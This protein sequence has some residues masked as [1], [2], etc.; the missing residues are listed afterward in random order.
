MLWYFISGFFCLSALSLLY[1][2]RKSKRQ[3]DEKNKLLAAFKGEHERLSIISNGT[4]NIIIIMDENGEIEW[5]NKVFT[6][7]TEYSLE[8]YKKKCGRTIYEVTSSP[9]L[10][11]IVNEAVKENKTM[12][13]ETFQI[14]S[15]GKKVWRASSISPIFDE[16]GS[17]KKLLIIDSDYT[18]KKKLEDDLNKLSLV[19]NR[20][21]SYVVISDK[22]D[23]IEW[24]NEAFSRITGYQPKEVIGKKNAELL[25]SDFSNRKIRNEVFQTVLKK[26]KKYNGEI[27]NYTNDGRPIWLSIEITPVLDDAG[28]I[29]QFVTTGSEITEKKITEDQLRIS[30]KILNQINALVL[31]ADKAGEITYANPATKSILGYDPKEIIGDAWWKLTAKSPEEEISK[32]QFMSDAVKGKVD[33]PSAPYENSINNKNGEIRWIRWSDTKDE[34]SFAVGIGLDITE[35]INAENRLKQYSRKLTLLND[36]GKSILLSHSLKDTISDILKK[37]KENFPQSVRISI[38]MFDFVTGNASFS[39]VFSAENNNLNTDAVI[40]LTAFGSLESLKLNQPYI[41]NNISELTNPSETDKMNIADG[42]RSYAVMP[43]LHEYGLLGSINLESE[44]CNAFSEDDVEL[45]QNISSEIAIALQQAQFKQAIHDS[46][47]L[48]KKRNEDI[49]ASLRYAKRLQEAIL[50]PYDYVKHLLPSSFILY[51]AKEIISGDF[52]WMEKHGE[53]ILIAAADCTGHGAPGAFMSIVGNNL[54]N[55]AVN[56]HNITQPSLILDFINT[57]LSKVLHNKVDEVSIKDGMDIVLCSLDKQKK[58]LEFSGA[59]NTLWLIRNRELII[60]KGDK[61]PVGASLQR[62]AKLFTNHKIQLLEGDALYMFSDGFAD[63]F[64]GPKGK[65]FKYN[66]LRELLLKIQDQSMEA[67]KLSLHN[68]IIKWKGDLEQVDDILVIGL[69]I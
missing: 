43:L 30:D 33:L 44:V 27:Y 11:N 47:V 9:D 20:T 21:G 35:R 5:V 51:Q 23:K 36:I 7:L 29:A 28:S 34:G 39:F 41:N 69:K 64:G 65:K 13:Y 52:Y 22:E 24:V 50:P 4:P 6:E 31:V 37:V 53:T 32:K 48:L 63:Q 2:L 61:F 49:N 26:H 42:I 67:Q 57:G 62:G 3:S 16:N 14:T 18:E 40:P 1:L 10:K 25:L 68:T 12:F 8:D 56:I 19:A 15:S 46:N 38:A 54:L 58:V 60:T 59:N 55:Q 17:L 45:L 66:Q